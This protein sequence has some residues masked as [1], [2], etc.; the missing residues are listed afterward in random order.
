M[1]GSA[2]NS[3]SAVTPNTRFF[4]LLIVFSVLCVRRNKSCALIALQPHIRGGRD[5]MS[6]VSAS[7]V[8]HASSIRCFVVGLSNFV[9]TRHKPN[10][11]LCI[12]G[13]PEIHEVSFCS[14]QK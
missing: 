12:E 6:T 8:A 11:F 14:L 3:F 7:R 1:P 2:E 9:T 5:S 13:W 10:I 4:L